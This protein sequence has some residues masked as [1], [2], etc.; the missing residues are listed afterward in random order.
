M[1]EQG[2]EELRA[3]VAAARHTKY[4]PYPAE[5]RR[6]LTAYA[7]QQTKRGASSSII[8]AELG[9]SD[10]T[11]QHW[12]RETTTSRR[13]PRVMRAVKVV[14]PKEDDPSFS[15]EGPQGLRLIGLSLD[16]VAALWR[17]LS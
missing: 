12:L 10:K 5:L 13:P 3:L 4:G 16:D 11:I 15:V 14:E 17:K 1:K 2:L 9:V 8:A 7:A 6:K